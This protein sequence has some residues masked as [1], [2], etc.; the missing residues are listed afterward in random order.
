MVP[1][2]W[3]CALA[4]TPSPHPSPQPYAY[5]KSAN[6]SNLQYV[7]SAWRLAFEEVCNDCGRATQAVYGGAS[8]PACF[9]TLRSTLLFYTIVLKYICQ[10]IAAQQSRTEAAQGMVLYCWYICWY[11]CLILLNSHR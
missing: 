9:A 10:T 8:T 6:L 4:R 1:G 7:P 11:R 3:P 2:L 5:G